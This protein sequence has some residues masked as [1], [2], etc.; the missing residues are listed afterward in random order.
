MQSVRETL[1]QSPTR[2]IER[3]N[4]AF[5]RLI[6]LYEQN[7]HTT[8][9]T[10]PFS[11]DAVPGKESIFQLLMRFCLNEQQFDIEKFEN[12]VQTMSLESPLP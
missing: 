7:P 3:W 8:K 4:S 5:L 12:M 9:E 10:F 2:T 11:I 6:T 1:L